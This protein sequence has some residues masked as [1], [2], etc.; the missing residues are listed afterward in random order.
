M[1][2][3]RESRLTLIKITFLYKGLYECACGVI[4]EVNRGSVKAKVTLSCGCY[5]K[6]YIGT[7][8]IVHGLHSHPL[9]GVWKSM[10]ERCYSVNHPTYKDYGAIGITICDEWRFNFMS[11]YNW[12]LSNGWNKELQVDKD[13][14]GGKIYSPDNCLLVTRKVNANNRRSNR[15]VEYNGRKQTFKMWSIELGINHNTLFSRLNM[16]WSID[17]AFTKKNST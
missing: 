6:E 15:I 2:N 17:E 7:K 8:S 10:K 3:V 5:R 1:A 11:F 13:I 14:N 4:K 12:A 16:G 9:Y